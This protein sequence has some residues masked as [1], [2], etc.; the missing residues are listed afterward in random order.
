MD[1]LLCLDRCTFSDGMTPLMY[2]IIQGEDEVITYL[3][4]ILEYRELLM[5]RASTQSP[6]LSIQS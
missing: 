2:A 6:F 4:K 3:L 5:K 1:S